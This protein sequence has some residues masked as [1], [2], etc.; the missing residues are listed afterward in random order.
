MKMVF[1]DNEE[2][3]F[4]FK[5]EKEKEDETSLIVCGSHL[6]AKSAGKI[7]LSTGA[8]KSHEMLCFV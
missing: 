1:G 5:P 4:L 6:F 2:L 7:V 8:K 3:S